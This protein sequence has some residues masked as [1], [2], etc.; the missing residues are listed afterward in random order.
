[1]SSRNAFADPSIPT[2]EQV[3][4]QIASDYSIAHQERMDMVSAINRLEKW[5]GQPLSMIPASAR[6]LRQKFKTFHHDQVG[7]TR[8]RVQNVRSL[9]LR[10]MRTVGLTTKL[11]PY[12]FPMTKE[13]Q[14][15]FEALPDRYAKTSLSRIMRYCSKQGILPDEVNDAV[16]ADFLSALETESLVKHCK[17]DHQTVCRVW[18]DMAT[19]MEAWPQSRLA[20]PRYDQGR[21]YAID[22]DLIHPA[23][24]GEIA[25]YL[26]FLEGTNLFGGLAKPFRPTSIHIAKGNIRR[27]LSALHLNGFDVMSL[28]SLQTMVAFDVFKLAMEW[29][30]QRNGQKTSKH[31]GEV[32]WTV[33]CI[34]V[35]HLECDDATKELYRKAIE[36]LRVQSTG[37]STKNTSALKQFDDSKV[38]HRLLN[39]P[40]DL[41]GAAEKASGQNARLLGQAAV[42]TLILIFAPMR[43]KNLG[44]LRIDENLNWIDDRLHLHIPAAQVKNGEELNFILPRGPSDRVREY[45]DRY[46]SMSLPRANP[47]LFP[48]RNGKP[49]DITALR[50]L[51]SN[52]LFKHTGICLTPHQFRHVAAKLLLEARPGHYEVVRKL[53]GHKSLSTAY[54]H[55]TGTETQAAIDLYD[56]VILDRKRGLSGKL[57]VDD[58]MPFLDP[59]NPF[60]KGNKR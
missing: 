53:L 45:I 2:F 8:R 6:F 25:E 39:Y 30:W 32:A 35:K 33:R 13:W 29:F 47:Y 34:A 12:L 54:D 42:A 19:T 20:V 38:V 28:H 24:H 16:A 4:D 11:A 59:L 31:I 41:F 22:D 40:D 49:K 21:I 5:F 26:K 48:G 23:L 56:S 52:T 58:N 43:I 17:R 3:R 7:A 37:L 55:Y 44:D 46:R 14:A 57:E 15:L 9:V 10:A 36:S 1:M 51:I 27:Y 60:L 18:N 50:R